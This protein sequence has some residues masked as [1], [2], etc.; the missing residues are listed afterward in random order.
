MTEVEQKIKDYF[1]NYEPIWCA[2]SQSTTAKLSKHL[3][4]THYKKNDIIYR[5]GTFPRGLYIIKSGIAKLHF[6]NADGKEQIVYMLNKNEMY[7]YRSLFTE[8]PSLFYITAITNCE[9]DVIDK[10]NFLKTI[11]ESQDLNAYFMKILALE[12]RVLFNKFTFFTLRPITEKIALSLLILAH[13][14]SDTNPKT[15]KFP[16]GEIACYAGTI[17]ETLSRQLKHLTKIGAI[18][19]NGRIITIENETLLFEIANL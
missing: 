8:S 16:K 11:R 6:I 19:N 17:L 15:I 3:V 2:I 4:T 7:G 1:L 18:K 13:K 14:F 10:D 12:F 5:E 9:I